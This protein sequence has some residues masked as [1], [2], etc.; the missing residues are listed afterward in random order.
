MLTG[1]LLTLSVWGRDV[2]KR[3]FKV[4]EEKSEMIARLIGGWSPVGLSRWRNGSALNAL[5][6]LL[7]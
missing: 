6:F 4:T 2:V 5:A 1:P 3:T 7:D